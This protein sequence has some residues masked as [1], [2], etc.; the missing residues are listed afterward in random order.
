MNHSIT[1]SRRGG[2]IRVDSSEQELRPTAL[3][4]SRE[5]GLSRQTRRAR[6]YRPDEEEQV[7]MC[8]EEDDD[9]FHSSPEQKI[10]S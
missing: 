3:F 5:S 7:V 6:P 4:Q 1:A 8:G 9:G 10:T 2:L